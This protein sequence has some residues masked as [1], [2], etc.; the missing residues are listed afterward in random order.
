MNKLKIIKLVTIVAFLT[1]ILFTALY[2]K[3]SFKTQG[4]SLQLINYNFEDRVCVFSD[5]DLFVGESKTQ[6][7]N[8]YWDFKFTKISENNIELR[9]NKLWYGEY[10]DTILDI[11]Y[12]NKLC[13]YIEEIAKASNVDLG[14]IDLIAKKI[15]EDYLNVKNQEES[16]NK[17]LEYSIAL[18]EDMLSLER[19]RLSE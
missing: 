17:I 16:I 5:N 6:I 1:L 8:N 4:R 14:N 7:E 18:N 12:L 2:N 10:N 11:D 15:Q 3:V 19:V 9:I 13:L